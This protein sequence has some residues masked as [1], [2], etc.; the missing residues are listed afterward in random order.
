MAQEMSYAYEGCKLSRPFE[1]EW[2]DI[3]KKKIANSKLILV[4]N[5]VTAYE[6]T[7]IFK[8]NKLNFEQITSQDFFD[9]IKNNLISKNN[10]NFYLFASPSLINELKSSANAVMLKS[11]EDY[12]S[13]KQVIRN[14]FILDLREPTISFDLNELERVFQ[15]ISKIPTIAGIDILSTN[16]ILVSKIEP[17]LKIY[18]ST[19]HIKIILFPINETQIDTALLKSA[20]TIELNC[21]SVNFDEKKD[22]NFIKKLRETL[23]LDKRVVLLANG[24]LKAIADECNWG[25]VYHEKKHPKYFD[26]LLINLETGSYVDNIEFKEGDMC[27]SRRMFPIFDE[28]LRLKTCSLYGDMA[29][30]NHKMNDLEINDFMEK[31]EKLCTRCINKKIHRMI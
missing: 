6:F 25:A 18:K 26:E 30:T 19:L 11:K 10:K 23:R 24:R 20:E 4:G 27:L 2:I 29:K 8:K 5:G 28:K 15:Y 17:V 31:R 1:V 21:A 7:V 13:Y 9:D 22:Q 14:R 3:L 16:S 12:F